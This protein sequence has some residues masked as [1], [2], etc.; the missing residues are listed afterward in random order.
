[1]TVTNDIYTGYGTAVNVAK[2][3]HYNLMLS[4]VRRVTVT[5]DI[6]TGYGTT[7]NVAKV[8]HYNLMLSDEWQ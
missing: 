5:N 8:M 6:C 4:C 3:M 1:V 7:V 2:V